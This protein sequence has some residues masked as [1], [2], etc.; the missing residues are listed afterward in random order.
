M[1]KKGKIGKRLLIS[2]F[3]LLLSIILITGL[4][5][6][7]ISHRYL[8]SVAKKQMLQ[9][10][11]TIVNQIEDYPLT[12]MSVRDRLI[13]NRELRLITSNLQAKIFVINNER[14]IIF[15]NIKAG[16]L[17]Q[18]SRIINGTKRDRDYV[19]TKLPI[20]SNSGKVVGQVILVA[21]AQDIKAINW[22]MGRVQLF[23]L[24]IAGVIAIIMAFAFEKRITS[25]IKKLTDYIKDFSISNSK[26]LQIKTG[27]EIE[28]LTETFNSLTSKLRDYD[29]K[30]M[31]F[32][33]NT[34]HELKT[35][36]MSIQGY[37]EAI[38]EGIVEG[39]DVKRSLEI[40][41]EESQRLK[42]TVDE[43]IYLTRLESSDN[44]LNKKELDL[45][46][47]VHQS[48]ERVRAIAKEREIN[49]NISGEYP[50]TTLNGEEILRAMVNIL[51]NCLRFANSHIDIEGHIK[52]SYAELVI[53]DDGPGFKEGEEKIVFERFYKG[54]NG[55]TGIGLAIVKAIIEGHGGT[56]KAKN[57]LPNG[58]CF[59]LNLPIK[60]VKTKK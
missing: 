48:V 44:S 3:T 57:M 31:R 43:V 7:I 5:F 58:A 1:A 9:E 54:E 29:E 22:L 38:K 46:D 33:Q 40:I 20:N 17:S 14:K 12:E 34:S 36:L 45:G 25:P 18:Y 27:D 41:I 11:K 42:K 32:L 39:D 2:Y 19:T 55:G 21:K 23:S 30:Q 6:N 37:A 4:T 47:I 49:I 16:E 10:G 26:P 28:D 8:V 15:S 13:A 35:P 51:G 56:V 24:I 52:E 50:V 53:K 60:C 59:T